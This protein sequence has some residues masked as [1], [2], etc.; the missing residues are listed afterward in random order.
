MLALRCFQGLDWSRFGGDDRPC[1]GSDFS[2]GQAYDIP[3]LHAKIS[4]KT[5]SSAILDAPGHEVRCPQEIPF[6]SIARCNAG[7]LWFGGSSGPRGG[8]EV[9]IVSSP[10]L[11]G[12]K[13]LFERYFG[14]YI[15]VCAMKPYLQKERV[16]LTSELP[17]RK[18]TVPTNSLALV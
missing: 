12:L 2:T 18:T 8:A 7:W 16:L 15:N 6:A 13:L 5:D 3:P 11:S 4:P 17:C 1:F 14:C 10:V 9:G